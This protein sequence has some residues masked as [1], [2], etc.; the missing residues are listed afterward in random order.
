MSND[1]CVIEGW[2]PD[3]IRAGQSG[4]VA[5]QAAVHIT[6]IKEPILRKAPGHSEF[7]CIV[8]PDRLRRRKCCAGQ[9]IGQVLAAESPPAER[10]W[11]FGRRSRSDLH[12][13]PEE[14]FTGIHIKVILIAV[15]QYAHILDRVKQ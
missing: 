6:S 8:I 1:I 3:F 11:S 9:T 12:D 13:L 10:F 15:N 4:V 7:E 5:I 2:S 14:S